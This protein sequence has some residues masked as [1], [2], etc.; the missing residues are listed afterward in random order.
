MPKGK[1]LSK[2]ERRY[3]KGFKGLPSSGWSTTI[4]EMLD[5]S[6][7][8]K[9]S[10]QQLIFRKGSTLDGMIS[11]KQIGLLNPKMAKYKMLRK[12]GETEW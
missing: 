10:R 3:V 7:K 1:G 8:S 11:D 6:K 4:D 5:P 9:K 12:E 2:R